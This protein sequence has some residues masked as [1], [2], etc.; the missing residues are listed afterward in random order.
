MPNMFRHQW[1]TCTHFA[2]ALRQSLGTFG[3]LLGASTAALAYSLSG[4]NY[5]ATFALASLP[6]AMALVLVTVVRG[7]IVIIKALRWLL[8]YFSCFPV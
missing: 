4:R 6:A 5:I 7:A 8:S 1:L 3:A 2:S